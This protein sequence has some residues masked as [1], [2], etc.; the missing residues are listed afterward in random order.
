MTYAIVAAIGVVLTFMGFA[1]EIVASNIVHVQNGREPSA[2]AAVFPSIP[3]VPLLLVGVAWGLDHI[4][5]GLGI[6]VV[7]GLF[8]LYLPAWF[9]RLRRLSRRL[10]SLK[11]KGSSSPS[12][13]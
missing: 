12:A 10:E 7:C 13:T 4:R 2:G 8:V 1:T 5:S 6:W 3:L 9:F 11:R